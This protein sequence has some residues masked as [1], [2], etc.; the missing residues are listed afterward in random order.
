MLIVTRSS[1]RTVRTGRIV[2]DTR[3]IVDMAD[4]RKKSIY[5]IGIKGKSKGKFTYVYSGG[6]L[7]SAARSQVVSVFGTKRVFRPFGKNVAL[8]FYSFSFLKL[9][10]II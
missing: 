8:W 5:M 2:C 10:E 7:R 3:P 9:L 1:V 4:A 6:A